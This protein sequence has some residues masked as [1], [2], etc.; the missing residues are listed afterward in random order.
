MN[1]IKIEVMENFKTKFKDAIEERLLKDGKM[2][3]SKI[4]DEFIWIERNDKQIGHL[5]CHYELICKDQPKFRHSPYHVHVEVHFEN[6]DTYQLFES[7]KGIP[8]VKVI[9]SKPNKR[10]EQVEWENIGLRTNEE[11]HC[12]DNI[13]MDNLVND[14]IADLYKTDALVGDAIRRIIQEKGICNNKD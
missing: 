14:V 2:H 4:D 7:I 6:D 1:F 10:G 3:I 5:D 8:G 11:G 13:S 9:I 12:I